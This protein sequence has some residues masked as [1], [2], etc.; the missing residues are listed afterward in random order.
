MS[1]EHE[2]LLAKARIMNGCI[3]EAMFVGDGGWSKER[4]DFALSPL[5]QDGIVWVDKQ[6][7]GKFFV[8]ISRERLAIK[9][10]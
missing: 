5:L 10:F 6:Q 3:N 8:M 4:F 1:N 7:H 9:K 2:E